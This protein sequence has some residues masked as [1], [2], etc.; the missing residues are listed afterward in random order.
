M[1]I[2]PQW[3]DELRARITLSSVVQRTTK[4][5]KAGREW[6]ACCPFHDETTP[7]FYVNDQ[8]GFYHCFGCGAHGDVITWMIEQR[9]LGFMDAIKELAAEAG[10]EVP[11][12]DPVAAKK[13][14]KRAELVDVTTAAQE[15]F[16]D[17]LR[18][19][20]GRQALEYLK[21]RGLTSDTLREFGFGYAPESKQALS[22][23][24]ARF[25]AQMLTESG[26]RIVTD[27][28]AAYDRFRGR[29]ML[30]IQ[31]AR[32]RV[33]AFGG[34]ILEKRDGVAKYLNSPDTPLFDKGRTLYNLHRAAPASR[35]SGRVVVVEG[36]MDVVALHQAGICDAV[37]PLGTALTETQLEM[38]WRMVDTPVLC[39]DGDAAGQRAAM[40]AIS[41]ALPMLGPMRSLSIVRLPSGLDPDDLIKQQGAQAMEQL[42]DQPASLLDV[43]WEVERDAQP[44]STPENKAGLKS[45]LMAHVDT[46]GDNDVRALYRR[47]LLDRFSA[48]A[49][50]PRPPRPRNSWQSGK[51]AVQ[52]LSSEA[53]SALKKA[54]S[55]GARSGLMNAVFAGLTRFPD[56]ID[57]HCEALVQLA[58]LDRDAAP[59]IE[60][61]IELSE[62]VDSPDQAAIFE[63]EGQLAPP[64][65]SR[66]AFLREGTPPGEA[67]EELAEAVSL[68][69]Q[70]PALE[71]AMAATIAR[72]D[73]D[74]EGSFAEQMRLRQQLAAVDER[75][76]AFG[77]RKAAPAAGNQD[78]G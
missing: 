7:S 56:Q 14:E 48:F 53:R 39:F 8:K 2:T 22:K 21:R 67:R 1:T 54:V 17:N 68:L 26:M 50:P 3:K 35:Q 42:L 64:D 34:R 18:A 69:A 59:V 71:A 37:A 16:V 25:E 24:L 58:R 29:V 12:P 31:D 38:L 78:A 45:R 40:R 75:L 4:L 60:S 36:Y 20:D 65:V 51:P 66:Y 62:R 15:W 70:K 57:R 13:A 72:F 44:L 43:L 76:K 41:R 5:T 63:I 52:P 49:Y 32:G 30:P 27:D 6:K 77:R 9:G 23:A 10:M 55:G 28:G 11:A 19:A 33:I 46:I 73:D 74:P 47:E 61:L